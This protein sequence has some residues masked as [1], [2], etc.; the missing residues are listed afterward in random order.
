M[1]IT[2]TATLTKAVRAVP[3]DSIY[4]RNMGSNAVEIIS[5]VRGHVTRLGVTKDE[6][7]IAD[8]E[9]VVAERKQ[10]NDDCS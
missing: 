8:V 6:S 3:S 1:K 5:V 10:S 9:R 7:L 2:P 4:W